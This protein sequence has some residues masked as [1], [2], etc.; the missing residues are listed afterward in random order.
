MFFE[1]TCYFK[2][3]L[4]LVAVQINEHHPRAVVA[5]LE[6]LHHGDGLD[7]HSSP[8]VIFSLLVVLFLEI[9][10]NSGQQGVKE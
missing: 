4:A 7:L 10:A 3:V 1:V 2:V 8:V 6:V 5:A 9:G